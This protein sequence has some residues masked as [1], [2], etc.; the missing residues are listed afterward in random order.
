MAG[1]RQKEIFDSSFSMQNMQAPTEQAAV[2][3]AYKTCRYEQA[4]LPCVTV[5]NLRCGLTEL[6]FSSRSA[7]CRYYPC[8]AWC[9][10]VMRL[11]YRPAREEE[12]Q[13]PVRIAPLTEHRAPPF[14]WRAAPTKSCFP[15]REHNKWLDLICIQF[16]P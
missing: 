2:K 1:P 6:P 5:P 8:T 14:F 12:V 7:G 9:T 10:K 15:P 16:R 4:E 11:T 3:P 13:Q